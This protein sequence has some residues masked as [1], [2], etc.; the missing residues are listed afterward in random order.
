M[1]HK[2]RAWAQRLIWI[3]VAGAVIFFGFRM[4]Y[5]L[6]DDFSIAH[7]THEAPHNSYWEI[8]P[9][10]PEEK[11]NLLSILQHPFFYI[12]KGAQSYAFLSEDGEHVVKFFKFK[13]LRPSWFVKLLPNISF[14]GR[15]KAEKSAKKNRLIE[16]VFNGYRLAY[17]VHRNESGLVYI[18]LNKTEDF[19]RTV[20]LFDK[21]GRKFELDLD[22]SVFVV[23]DRVT[24]V[25]DVMKDALEKGDVAQANERVD[26]IIDLYLMEYGKGIYDRDHGVMHNIGFVGGRAI[27][28]DVGKL[29]SDPNMTKKENFYPDFL[30]VRTRFESWLK[31]SYPQYHQQIMSHMERQM[32]EAFGEM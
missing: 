20:V 16:S 9:L 4:Y 3:V 5:R 11:D 23:Q 13:H 21:I 2:N 29:S 19:S 31:S 27:H 10:S 24:T 8:E 26:K 18:H 28:L 14:F 22:S 30:I 17:D 6:T 1:E 7:I 25:R 32:G 15:Y 12:G